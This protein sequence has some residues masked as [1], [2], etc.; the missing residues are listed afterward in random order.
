MG[1]IT[2]KGL[3][4]KGAVGHP[5]PLKNCP[6]CGDEAV[7]EPHSVMIPEA[8]AYHVICTRCSVRMPSVFVKKGR[9]NA[10]LDAQVR[11]CLYWNQRAPSEEE[12][13]NE[14]DMQVS[15]IVNKIIED[16][17]EREAER[18]QIIREQEQER[19]ERMKSIKM[20]VIAQ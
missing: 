11:A 10:E 18:Q 9:P 1:L 7:L 5:I 4:Y 12:R 3:Y 8:K 16:E 13:R 17:A 19:Q 6:F 2:T 20:E 14:F 15:D